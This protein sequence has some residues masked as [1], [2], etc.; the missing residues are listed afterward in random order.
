VNRRSRLPAELTI[1]SGK[2]I[3]LLISRRT[4]RISA[5]RA[6]GATAGFSVP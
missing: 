6:R 1:S 5:G 4:R 3:N 2:V